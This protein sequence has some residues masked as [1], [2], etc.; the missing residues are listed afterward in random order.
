[1]SRRIARSGLY[2]AA[3]VVLTLPSLAAAQQPAAKLRSLRTALNDTMEMR[4]FQAPMTLKE[5]LQLIQDKLIARYK[6]EDVLPILVDAAAFK[7]DDE[8]SGD[9]YDAQVKF[10]PYPRRMT[11]GMALRVI[12]SQVPTRT[13]TFI[14]RNGV[15]EITT[16]KEASL[17]RLLRQKVLASF[18]KRPCLDAIA[19]LSA[20]S[21]VSVVVDGRVRD[22]AKT[23][24]TAAFNND[25]TVEGALHLLADM[26]DLKLVVAG[27]TVYVTSAANAEALRKDRE[28][29]R[30]ERRA[31]EAEMRRKNEAGGK[32]AEKEPPQG[33]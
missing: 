17:K 20:L 14:L 24:V 3:L 33:K 15:V 10:P 23:P 6:D 9:I 21:G 19:D 16:E 12:L 27:D 32:K 8:D 5:A 25:A 11:V 18:D 13:A 4:D 26:A 28:A 2:L 29:A 1:M 7:A 22:K 31:E 30:E